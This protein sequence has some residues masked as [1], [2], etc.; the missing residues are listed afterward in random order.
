MP[1]LCAT[2]HFDVFSNERFSRRLSLQ[3]DS[4]LSA[5][6]PVPSARRVRFSQKQDKV[7]NPA[8]EYYT[9]EDM[10][11]KWIGFDTL[12]DIRQE[13]R[14][15]SSS[16]RKRQSSPCNVALAHR[17]TT[18]IIASDLQSLVKLSHTTPEEDLSR[19]CSIDD[20]RR[21][22]ERFSSGIYYCFRRRDISCVRS[23][24][25]AE[26]QRQRAEH[27]HDLD[28]I[29]QKSCEVSRRSRNFALFLGGADAKQV[30]KRGID[31]APC[32]QVP[33]RKRSK[34][35]HSTEVASAA[36]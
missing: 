11:R 31:S 22:L 17:K 23:V 34:V 5:T 15:L 16:L 3:L 35:Y 9:D 26:Q 29:A 1:P 2:E 13:A 6:I 8:Q 28:A 4:I 21:G 19:W 14:E 32:R 25:L 27:V 30:Q 36:A 12:Q 18:L 7:F 33:P 24:V 20:G 10:E